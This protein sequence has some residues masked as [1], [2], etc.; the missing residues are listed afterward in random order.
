MPWQNTLPAT[1][2]LAG[3]ASLYNPTAGLTTIAAGATTTFTPITPSPI[4]GFSPCLGLSYEIQL[5][6][7]GSASAT[8][9]FAVVT[10]QFFESDSP[11]AFPLETVEWVCAVGNVGNGGLIG[12]H[13]PLRGNYMSVTIKNL[14]TLSLQAGVTILGTSR[15]YTRDVWTEQTNYVTAGFTRPNL[16]P[17]TLYLGAVNSVAVGAGLTVAR[18]FPMW[19]GQWWIEQLDTGGVASPNLD[20]TVQAMPPSFFTSANILD[21][22]PAGTQTTGLNNDPF[23]YFIAGPRCPLRL[24]WVNSGTTTATVNVVCTALEGAA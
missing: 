11:G 12:G 6:L 13:G 7:L 24:Q 8:I 5:Q 20:F 19:A 23:G 2:A 10:L 21:Q 16:F 18:L 1:Q 15:T 14:D 4:A 9:P 3:Q 22:F 17:G